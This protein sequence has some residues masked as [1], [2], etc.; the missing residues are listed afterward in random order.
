MNDAVMLGDSTT[1]EVPDIYFERE[2]GLIDARASAGEWYMLGARDGSWMLPVVEHQSNGRRLGAS[3]Y[4]YTGLYLS[5]RL[6]ETEIRQR[7]AE[8]VSELRDR[9]MV[10]LF[11]RFHPL[12]VESARRAARL[13]GLEVARTSSTYAVTITDSDVMWTRLEGR[14]RTE[15]R[16]AEKS[17]MSAQIVPL[18]P[19]AVAADSE[20][21]RLY[22][23]TMHRVGAADR[24]FFD[25]QYFADLSALGDRRMH[26]AE[27]QHEGRVVASAI[28]MRHGRRAHYHL[29]GSD[30]EGARLG[31]N[32]LM[33]WSVIE[34]CSAERLKVF[35]LGGG[36]TEDDG[37]ARFK[38]SFADQH[39]DFFTG[40]V[41]VDPVEYAALTHR[42]AVELGTTSEA[43]EAT[44]YF[45]A[46]LAT[47]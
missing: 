16:K 18:E 32:S 11:L 14:A 33:L 13:P 8:A 2:Y 29:S 28:I 40:R 25:D 37:L 6:E 47:V 17:G 21:R 41:V 26:L 10:S 35:H 24:Y 38:R 36:V 3:P 31:A 5:P 46:F 39:L 43:L 45:P 7:W 44:G 15:V 20:F 12:D 27:V 22:E 23:G 4:G 9:G 1:F 19:P 34:W 30:R 42:R